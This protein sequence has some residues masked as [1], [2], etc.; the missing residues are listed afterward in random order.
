MG[1]KDLNINN[2]FDADKDLDPNEMR[3]LKEQ[4][5]IIAQTKSKSNEV[6]NNSLDNF[7][8]WADE[9]ALDTIKNWNIENIEKI[10]DTKFDNLKD[11]L[12]IDDKTKIDSL[13]NN[14]ETKKIATFQIALVKVLKRWLINSKWQFQPM[15]SWKLLDVNDLNTDWTLN[16]KWISLFG[17]LQVWSDTYWGFHGSVDFMLWSKTINLVDQ[18]LWVMTKKANEKNNTDPINE[19]ENE[20]VN[21]MQINQNKNIINERINNTDNMRLSKDIVNSINSFV[22]RWPEIWPGKRDWDYCTAFTL[23]ML[24]YLSIKTWFNLSNAINKDKSWNKN[25]I[26]LTNTRNLDENL[27]EEYFTKTSLKDEPESITTKLQNAKIWSIFTVTYWATT[28]IDDQREN[29]KDKSTVWVTHSLIKI[30]DTQFAEEV[31]WKLNY[32]DI[33]ALNISKKSDF[34]KFYVKKLNPKTGETITVESTRQLTKEYSYFSVKGIDY[35]F[36][37]NSQIIEPK[38]YWIKANLTDTKIDLSKYGTNNI[39][40][41]ARK[42]ANEYWL[43]TMYILSEITKQNL[44]INNIITLTLPID[45]KAMNK[46]KIKNIN[47]SKEELILQEEDYLALAIS[48]NSWSETIS[49]SAKM[50][51]LLYKICQKQNKVK[52]EEKKWNWVSKRS[53]VVWW[54]TKIEGLV[55]D[56]SLGKN[57]RIALK[58]ILWNKYNEKDMNLNYKELLSI[59]KKEFPSENPDIYLTENDIKNSEIIFTNWKWDKSIA[60]LWW[61]NTKQYA[62]R[63]INN[64]FENQKDGKF[65]RSFIE[66]RNKRLSAHKTRI[67]G[68]EWAMMQLSDDITT[69]ETISNEIV[70]WYH[71]ILSTLNNLTNDKKL[72]AYIIARILKETGISKVISM[73]K[74]GNELATGIWKADSVWIFELSVWYS[75]NQILINEKDKLWIDFWDKATELAKLL[76]WATN[77]KDWT[78]LST[79]SSEQKEAFKE[80][81]DLINTDI[82]LSTKLTYSFRQSRIP[83]IKSKKEAIQWKESVKLSWTI[84]EITTE[85]ATLFSTMTRDEILQETD[86]KLDIS[87]TILKIKESKYWI[88]K[89]ISTKGQ[90]ILRKRFGKFPPKKEGICIQWSAWN[91]RGVINKIILWD[92]PFGILKNGIVISWKDYN[93][94]TD[95]SWHASMVN[96]NPLSTYQN[97]TVEFSTQWVKKPY[98]WKDWVDIDTEKPNDIQIANFSN[99]L[100][101]Y[102]ERKEW[103]K[104]ARFTSAQTILKDPSTIQEIGTVNSKEARQQYTKR[105]VYQ[106]EIHV[107]TGLR[108]KDIY[109]KLWVDKNITRENSYKTTDLVNRIIDRIELSRILSWKKWNENKVES[110]RLQYLIEI[111]DR[112]PTLTQSYCMWVIL[113]YSKE[114]N[115]V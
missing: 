12:D 54:N 46:E 63:L 19:N 76:D 113:S 8:N 43:S 9:N 69:N 98:W 77:P 20:I 75:I 111:K 2:I 10:N 4:G 104:I 83:I 6:M 84:A 51:I 97:T 34:K 18:I 50:Q 88:L 21:T 58:S 67:W 35:I 57:S 61:L 5:K 115:T 99:L 38:I 27:K 94:Q 15:H 48:H 112:L 13:S 37:D 26:N 52:V 11:K 62:D 78:L 25:M 49:S 108:W 109:D 79:A 41:L 87:K 24:N 30:S 31:S 7:I 103:K 39:D 1:D 68:R 14:P 72:K 3:M 65:I 23:W 16:Q 85:Q 70:N 28:H 102:L 81:T 22:D 59:Y 82:V 100:M 36:T 47:T 90:E 42:I 73:K 114:K 53:L 33:S 91:D 95:S 86:G 96:W 17:Q 89:N 110:F 107:D 64:N 92:I 45:Q 74:I 71:T 44:D 101:P 32:I 105:Y 66:E 29:T 55:F 60:I 106:K 93:Y 80:M 56:W 40:E